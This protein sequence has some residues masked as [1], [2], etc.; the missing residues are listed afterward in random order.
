[1]LKS[2]LL[3]GAAVLLVSADAAPSPKPEIGSYGLDLTGI[4]TTIKP[5]DDFYQYAVGGWLTKTEIPADKPQYGMFT[6]LADL[7]EARTRVIIEGAASTPAASGSESQKVG[8]FYRAFMDEKTI[9]A[10]GISPLMTDLAKIAAIKTKAQ[11]ATAL[12]DAVRIGTDVPLELAIGQDDKHPDRYIASIGQGGLGLPDMEYYDLKNTQFDK[13][14]KA[15]KSYLATLFSLTKFSDPAGRADK[16]YALEAKIAATHWTKVENRDPVKTYNLLSRAQM[17]ALAPGFD[18]AAYLKATGTQA[19]PQFN[20]N[21]PSAITKAAALV[22]ATPLPVWQDYLRAHL[23][24]ASSPYLPQAFVDARFTMYGKTLAGTPNLRVRWKRGVANTEGALGEVV[25]KLYVAQHFTPDTKAR[26]DALV[27]N[28]LVA[29]GQRLDGLDW[30]SPETKTLAKAKLATYMP[31]IGYPTKW[32]DYSALTIKPDDARG[33]EQRATAFEFNRQLAKLGQPVDRT[34]WGMFPQT[35]NAYY[36]A[37][38]N[39]IVFPAA[40]LQPPFFDPNADDAVNYGGIGAVIG[41]EI[42]HGFDDQGAEYD[43]KGALNNWWTEG[44]KAKFKTATARLVEQYNGYCPFPGPTPPKQCVNGKL[45]L[46]ENIA[47][48]AGLTIAYQAYHLSLKGKDAP[49]I[50]GLT[51]DQRFFLGFEQV[52]RSKTRDALAQNWLVSDEHSPDRARGGVVRNLDAWYVAFNI[53]PGD[54]QY[55]KPEDR[56]RIW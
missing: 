27:Q 24:N 53:K 23:I 41:H 5:G 12:G 45:T 16:V 21:Q 33:N 29:M 13:A 3:A 38:L 35:V 40:I 20:V 18:W 50:D 2:M 47:D 28:L 30:M 1:M 52:W 11:L 17:A 10:R 56:V 44:D 34:E 22:A 39:E 19:Q 8:D 31:K 46:G 36:N 43:A 32:R 14:R 9:S 6:K 42:S 54:K 4:D 48:L 55:L 49:V 15:Y 51:G 7:S 26:A 37:V 25:G